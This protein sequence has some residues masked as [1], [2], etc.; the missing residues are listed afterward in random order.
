MS[1][2]G[3]RLG[4]YEILERLGQGGMGAVY[5]ARQVTLDRLVALKT[6][7]A[8]IAADPEYIA[9][10][11]REAKA[12]A[13]LIHPNLVQV[14]SAGET[15][16]LHW[17]AMEFVEGESAQDRLK[18]KGRLDPE[19]AIAIATHVA[20]AL[21][22][23]WRKAQLIHRDIK[24]DN[25]FLSNDGEVKL[26][27]LGLAKSAGETQSLTMTGSSMGTPHYVS[28]E[29]GQGKK[30]VD[31]RADIYSLGCTLFH[32]V[33]GEAPFKGD[34]ALA[35]M[36]QHVTAPVPNL[37]S[38]WPECPEE[39][40]RVVMKMML[41]QPAARQQSYGE[42]IADLRRAYDALTGATMPARVEVT[43][44]PAAKKPAQRQSPAAQK[45]AAKKS[46]PVAALAGIGLALL[47]AI[48]ALFYFAP[49]KKGDRGA[50]ESR[51][52]PPAAA[53]KPP[54][55]SHEQWQ[56]LIPGIKLPD[57][58]RD[59]TTYALNKPGHWELSGGSLRMTS[60]RGSVVVTPAVVGPDYDVEFKLT[61]SKGAYA[62]SVGL[63]VGGQKVNWQA[64]NMVNR[65][66]C[67]FERI[68]NTDVLSGPAS[69]PDPF[70]DGKPHHVLL[71][72]RSL[73]DGQTL[74]RSTI[75]SQ[76]S[77]EWTGPAS[78]L[79]AH[80]SW[81]HQ[82]MDRLCLGASASTT[83]AA[84]EVVFA[85]V[86]FRPVAA[87]TLP[88]QAV[89]Q[90]PSSS[91]VTTATKGK[92]FV[93]TL[94]MK[95][96]PVPIVSGP[97]A[98][99]RVLFGVWDVRV[100]DYAVYAG[101]KKVDDAWTKQV[102]DGVPAGHEL[103]HPVVGVSWED[104]QGF[105]Q[106][107][108][109][110]EI[111]EGKLPKGLKYRLPTDEEWSRAVGLPPELGA[112]PA[113]KKEKN[114]VEFPWGKEYPPRGKVGNYADE[115]FHP[116]FPLKEDAKNDW[117]K[118]RWIEG[119]TDGYATTSP[120]GC[121]PANAYGLYDMGGNVWQWCEDWFDESHKD[122]VLRGASWGNYDS[123]HLLSSFRHHLTPWTRNF[124]DG[125][126][127]VLVPS[128]VENSTPVQP[129]PAQPAASSS[130]NTIPAPWKD[131][132]DLMAR[133]DPKRDAVRG[134]WSF[135]GGAFVGDGNI[136]CTL[137]IPY[138]PS[139]EYDFRIEFTPV[140]GHGACQILSKAGHQFTANYFAGTGCQSAGFEMIAGQA[141][142]SKMNN[143]GIGIGRPDADR[144]YT[145]LVEVRNTGVKSYLDGKLI[146]SWKTDYADMGV[147]DHFKLRSPEAIGLACEG[148]TAFHR[149]EVREVTGTGKIT[150][151]A[152]PASNA[153]PMTATKDAPFVNTLGMKFVP[154]PIL[155]GPTG[156]K[157]VLFGV[158][159]VRVQDYAVY[160]ANAAK[161]GA[162]KVDDSWTKQE[163]D[164]VPVGREP[165]HP[166]VCVSWDDAQGFC[167]WLTEKESAEGKLPK[168]LKYR[169]PAD[170]EWSWA[171]GLPPELGG[172][173]SEKRWKNS[174]DFPWGKDWPPTKKVGNYA[175]ETF[176]GK[177]PK[178]ANDKK[179]DQPWLVGYDDGY[180]T[181]SPVGSFPAN[182]YGLYDMGGNMWQWC[183]D[184]FDA[185][186]KDRVLRGAS[187]NHDDRS[188]LMSSSRNHNPPGYRQNNYGFRCVLAPATATPAAI[189]AP[190]A[191]E[192]W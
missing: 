63:P 176:H 114:K 38:V 71:S 157:T 190:P 148:R 73:A 120:V 105:C 129:N 57:D 95:F 106:W 90:L 104:A 115:T 186:H 109:E 23:G 60:G 143:T 170:E 7:Q 66:S 128:A 25:I 52:L 168:G 162:K 150:A 185:S 181:T 55:A 177:F 134:T 175:D 145:A 122:R 184:W 119:Y 113:E 54:D 40:A 48:A 42:V 96:V 18:R 131:G 80:P 29:Q 13:A 72:V 75:D 171:V 112:T 62:A 59:N 118:N 99:Q 163:R 58:V 188:S 67:G 4:E 65:A 85:E 107:L 160:A 61:R 15:D 125:F 117:D 34:T 165:N 130:A 156:G 132:I 179:K 187:W 174:V 169:L 183:E 173:P 136:Y 98:G 93:N 68:G 152:A 37:R 84:A 133:I 103:N 178:D 26:G 45:A 41:K 92:P 36:M 28:P 20:T 81:N 124:I 100:Q 79:S 123:Y 21:D 155:G 64:L 144:R 31:L 166:V 161:A 2:E 192:P 76:P 56:D 164:G 30:D 182:A 116:N 91:S 16:G 151:D 6:L 9:R 121:F 5:K 39:L 78:E 32:L 180:A 102:K 141:V 108:T 110:K 153:T 149:I 8:A 10:F 51:P 135:E 83:G 19:E 3:Q 86:R 154:V 50:D 127:C 11:R 147:G 24:P 111:A 88:A 53:P 12:A 158:W 77:A 191:T 33:S 70:V 27:D 126:R 46:P 159:D 101:A 189:T 49:W 47:A 146:A 43:Q 167:Q 1:L 17:F 137:Q 138:A 140:S 97:T 142:W 22:Y 74:L 87:G 44:Q 69:A 94:G 89:S 172:T 139:A 14:F 82:P 35:V